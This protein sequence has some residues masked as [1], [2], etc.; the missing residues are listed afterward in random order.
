MQ[1]GVGLSD[2]ADAREAVEQAVGQAL[3]QAGA[4]SADVA[5]LFATPGHSDAIGPLLAAAGDALGSH[6]IVG[7]TAHGVIGDGREA[8]GRSGLAVAAFAGLDA[9]PFLLTGLDPS[10][11]RV[12]DE[13]LARLGG[14]ARAE[15]L[16]VLLPDPREVPLLAVLDDVRERLGPAQVVGAGA[17]DPVWDR[18][19]QW[20]DREVESGAL[21][22]VVLRGER[23]PRIGVT[24]ACRP[25]TEPFTVTRSQGHWILELDGRPALEVYREAARGP[26]ADDLRRAAGF[27]L[28]ALPVDPDAA[29]PLLPGGYRVRNVAGFAL[30]EQAFA[31]PDSVAQGDRLALAVRD[32]ESARSDMKEMLAGLAGGAPRAGLYFDCCARGESF[33]GVSGLEAGYLSQAFGDLPL[34]G[35]FGSCEI[36]PVGGRPELLTYTGVL[37]LLD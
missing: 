7:A 16:V 6:A 14:E 4:A 29:A 8:E 5:L 36:G 32:P 11:P 37:A 31:V 15:D 27:V 30:E 13:I 9:E 1:A 17:A 28:A 22:G 35:M 25:V 18:P 23:A 20:C 33:F 21:A 24:Q 2:S 12:A 10:A 26:L 19:L 34:A 3:A